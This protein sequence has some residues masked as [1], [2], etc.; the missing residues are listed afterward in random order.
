M[1]DLSLK[2]AFFELGHP[3]KE[4]KHMLVIH[5]KSP[6]LAHILENYIV[7]EKSDLSYDYNIH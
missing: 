6:D 5:N 2:L 1:R 3:C 7:G 4:S